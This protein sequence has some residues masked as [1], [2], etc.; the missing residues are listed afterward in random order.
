[1]RYPDTFASYHPSVN[2][3]YFASVL[4]FGMWF[5][6]PVCL[7]VSVVCAVAYNAY[8]NGEKSLRFCLVYM[9]PMLC[10]AA[11]VNPLFTHEGVT[12]LW[13]FPSGSALTLESILYGLAAAVMLVSVMVWFASFNSIMTTDKFIYL[14]GRVIPSLSLVLSMTLRFIPRFKKQMDHVREARRCMGKE[15]DVSGKRGALK[16]ALTVLSIMITWALEGAID[17]ADSMNSRGYGLP[18]RTAFSVYFFEA[19][20]RFCVL[21]ILLCDACVLA[22]YFAGLFDWRYYPAVNGSGAAGIPGYLCLALLGVTPLLID[23]K[24]DI[25]WKRIRSGI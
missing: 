13:Y 6:H 3:L 5:M 16:E 11:V 23:I 12:V 2:F 8:L 15:Q 4:L 20:D 1:M 21:W 7:A 22:S 18:G 25:K 9:L 14:F 19:R 10:L 24:E 17:T